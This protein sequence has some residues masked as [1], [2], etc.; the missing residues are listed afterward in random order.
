MLLRAAEFRATPDDH[1]REA[2]MAALRVRES[3]PG[4]DGITFM[5]VQAL[6]DHDFGW[7][8]WK[9]ALESSKARRPR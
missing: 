3:A 1:T 4:F 5:A 9:E 2:L 8:H 7:L 6:V